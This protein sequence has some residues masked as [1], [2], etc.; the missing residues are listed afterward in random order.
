MAEGL[1]ECRP[2]D[3]RPAPRRRPVRRGGSSAG[4]RSPA[5]ASARASRMTRSMSLA[6]YTHPDML[7]HAPPARPCRSGRSGCAAVTG[8]AGGRLGSRSRAAEAPLVERGGPRARAHRA[9]RGGAGARPSRRRAC[10]RSIARHLA[11]ARHRSRA[12]R[13]AAGAVAA[14]VRRGGG[15]RG[16]SGPS[17]PCGRP[18]TTPGRT[19]PMGFCLY[20]NVAIGAR[21]AQAGGP[22]RGSRWSIST[23]TTATARRTSSQADPTCSSPRSISAPG[24]PGTGDPSE[25][26]VGNVAN[27]TVPPCAPREVWRRGVRG[28]DGR[29]WTPSTPT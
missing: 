18:A 15:R 10:G 29:G 20:S 12:A 16:A 27:A 19:T 23:C 14:A 13:R 2:P 28:A 6:L 3:R 17:A 22:A 7:A 25:T 1:G 24:W 5:S 4:G 11:L 9:L 8:R 21:V 26:G